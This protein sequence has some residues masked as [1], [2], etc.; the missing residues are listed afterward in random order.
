MLK[1]TVY[2]YTDRRFIATLTS[3]SLKQV[4]REVSAEAS[5]LSSESTAAQM[6]KE[7]L[8]KKM[9]DKMMTSLN[10]IIPTKSDPVDLSL[11]LKEGTWIPASDF[12]S[13]LQTA[14]YPH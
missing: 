7:D 4:Q 12:T 14:L 10:G 3:K 1:V 5:K 6:S 9:R 2:H 8:Y 11:E 13:I